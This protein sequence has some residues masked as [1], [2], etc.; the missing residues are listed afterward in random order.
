MLS[1]KPDESDI[2]LCLPVVRISRTQWY[3]PPSVNSE[4][5]ESRVRLD[6]D[7]RLGSEF[8]TPN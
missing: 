4:A 2:I 6:C 5:E 3:M 8:F 1:H 7:I